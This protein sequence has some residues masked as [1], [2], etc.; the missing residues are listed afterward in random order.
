MNETRGF[1]GGFEQG[2]GLVPVLALLALATSPAASSQSILLDCGL[3]ISDLSLS[4][5]QADRH[6][7]GAKLTN[8]FQ[9][10]TAGSVDA[11]VYGQG[12]NVLAMGS[13]SFV[14][15]SYQ[16]ESIQIDLSGPVS[17]ASVY[18]LT[19][20]IGGG[21][22]IC[23]SIY[24]TLNPFSEP[25]RTKPSPRP[26]ATPIP[27]PELGAPAVA[28]RAS[29]RLV[30]ATSTSITLEHQGGDT[31]DL[32][33]VS[34]TVEGNVRSPK[35]LTDTSFSVGERVTLDF[36]PD[37]LPAGGQ[38]TLTSSGLAIATFILP[39]ATSSP[40]P[41]STSTASPV[42]RATPVSTATTKLLPSAA[43]L[44]P[45]WQIEKAQA[46]E[47]PE[48]FPPHR[49][50]LEAS[51]G[52]VT[53]IESAML[54]QGDSFV[55]VGVGE[56]DSPKTAM[57][58]FNEFESQ[59]AKARCPAVKSPVVGEREVRIEILS[60]GSPRMPGVSPTLTPTPKCTP[61]TVVFLRNNFIAQIGGP[62][63]ITALHI[64]A[65]KLIDNKLGASIAPAV[66]PSPVSSPAKTPGFEAVLAIAAF[67]LIAA[68][69]WRHR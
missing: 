63:G 11:K 37:T 18:S 30:E 59:A 39:S 34:V 47:N 15:P 28:P 66:T 43:D 12:W 19:A 4:V 21:A 65:A 6:T 54:K 9:G 64:E 27:S 22:V 55:Q 49:P 20:S 35:G 41:V 5:A 56:Y 32:T 51:G 38:V 69:F 50:I 58:L 23:E 3:R 48:P 60:L 45:E 62:G 42:P 46:M 17:Q 53:R 2:L 16:P 13:T 31:L 61:D 57:A 10:I 8:L 52:S 44:P 40:T 68:A 29:L 25:G 24:G 14:L 26:V 7:I 67:G 36:T 33:R 1:P